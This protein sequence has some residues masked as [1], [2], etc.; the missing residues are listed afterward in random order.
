M[1][2]Q[3]QNVDQ[4]M[5]VQ[6]ALPMEGW[7]YDDQL[8]SSIFDTFF[9]NPSAKALDDLAAVVKRN[10]ENPTKDPINV[11]AR[12][13]MS[14]LWENSSNAV[15]Y[16]RKTGSVELGKADLTQRVNIAGGGEFGISFN[17]KDI[18][19][20]NVFDPAKFRSNLKLDTQQGQDFMNALWSQTMAAEGKTLGKK[21]SE[22]ALQN[23]QSLLKIA[24]IG[25]ANKIAE[26]SQFVARRAGLAGFSGI[27]GAFL[28]TGAGM[29]PL[30][31]LGIA[32]LAKHQG[33]I[34]SSPQYLE[35]IV[36]TVDD[37]MSNKIRRANAAKLARVLLDDP[38]NESV[39]GLDFD[40]P[41][42]VMQYMFTNEFRPSSEP[43]GD[44]DKTFEPMFPQENAPDMGPVE[45]GGVE[46]F[47]KTSSNN[48]SNELVTKPK[49]NFVASNVSSPFRKVGGATFSPEKRAALAGG[50]LYEAIATAKRGG[51]IKKQGIMYFSGRRRP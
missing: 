21:G 11:A 49:T 18:V 4:N 10:K 28:A 51:S 17:P 37:T 7:I 15:A 50:N 3:F 12:A 9:A 46:Q 33:K 13:Y 2:K 41:E 48:M 30:T 36:S 1:A 44:V 34:L 47:Q 31:G 25:Y 35:W 42:A 39:Q 40:D 27:T 45:A 24:E 29:S 23:L 22:A 19:T 16:N 14:Q 32:L 38:D 6:G 5:F 26:T 20:V 43:E 8:A